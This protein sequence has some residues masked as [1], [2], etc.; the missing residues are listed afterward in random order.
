MTSRRTSQTGHTQACRRKQKP[1]SDTYVR[2]LRTGAVAVD[3]GPAVV[4]GDGV[5]SA[6]PAR[7]DR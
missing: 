7:A 2:L 1:D 6:A 3:L 5:A 4:T